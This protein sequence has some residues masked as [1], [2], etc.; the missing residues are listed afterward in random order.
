MAAP[1]V[2][3]DFDA[4]FTENVKPYRF[5]LLGKTWELPGAV[6]AVTVL[7]YQKL[8]QFILSLEDLTDD[9]TPELPEGFEQKDLSYDSVLREFAGDAMVDEW[10][11]LGLTGEHVPAVA[12]RLINRYILNIKPDA[13]GKAPKAPQDRRPAKKTVSTR[14]SSS[15]G[16]S[17]T[18]QSSKPTGKRSTAATST[19]T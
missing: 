16:S 13:E 3:D 2:E 10:F 15:S 5:K 6:P 4:W 7:R 12:Q 11:E 19:T 14:R 9:E 17:S 8:L 18:G 1:P